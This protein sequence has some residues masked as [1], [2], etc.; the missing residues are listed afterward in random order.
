[1]EQ[2]KSLIIAVVMATLVLF[3]WQHFHEK[4]VVEARKSQAQ[5]QN[6][7]TLPDTPQDRISVPAD[8]ALIA[9]KQAIDNVSRVK[10]HSDNLQGSISLVGARIDDI[11]LPK[12]L[13]TTN[14]DSPPV[15]LLSPAKTKN[16]Y[17]AEFGW[18]SSSQID[19]P[20]SKTLWRADKDV[21]TENSKLI[22]QWINKQGIRF[23][24]EIFLDDQYM[25]SIKQIINNKSDK[26][27]AFYNYGLVSRFEEG[28][29]NFFIS[30]EGAIG[31]FNNILHETGYEDLKKDKKQEFKSNA[32]GSW[33]GISDK[34][35]L[36][37]VIPDFTKSYDSNFNYNTVS[38][39]DQYQVDFI[40][41]KQIL[42][43]G[44]SDSYSTHFFAGAKVL[45]VLE[46][47]EKYFKLDLF[48][49]A[50][51]FG[52]FYFIT[53]PMFK[54]LMFFYELLGNF[55]LSILLVTIIVKAVLFPLANK[56]FK[57]MNKMKQLQP[58]INRIRELY[59]NDKML[60]NKEI[61]ELYKRERVNP[62]SGCLPLLIQIPIFFS[63]Y[64]VLFITIEMRHA[65]FYG[66]IH[67]LSAPDPT[68]IFNL[69]GLL[70]FNPPA[71]LMIGV[72]PIIMALTMYIQQLLNPQP[73]DPVQ[74]KMMK[75]LPAIFLFMFSSFP[76][77]LVI[78]WAWSN[79]LS[80]LQQWLLQRPSKRKA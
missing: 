7:S 78:Y 44:E 57:S 53:K 19:L 52:W 41:Q 51:D 14:P 56:S 48:D 10:I 47:Y 54:A 24:I 34:Y 69:F 71:V 15:T 50:I 25:F 67:D 28:S 43:P 17:F 79:T 38:G 80:I 63:L 29:K 21:L 20:N 13:V 68:S 8:S 33:F 1:M 70:P 61:M 59:A 32:S 73:A 27:I 9:R 26:T 65:P 3:A 31:V 2:T 39:H 60:Q 40:T 77:G 12:Y 45:T 30:H 49:R 46:G 35:W 76:A 58:Q 23:T 36:T 11:T 64:K 72:W 5:V 22:L 37:A 18:L 16:A 55:G 4:P 75:L 62:L 66:W 6:D 42:A 74:A